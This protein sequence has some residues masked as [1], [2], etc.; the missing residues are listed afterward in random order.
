MEFPIIDCHAHI[1]PPLAGA[2]GLPMPPRICCTSSAPCTSTAT[3]RI[4]GR[5]TM[6]S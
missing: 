6:R 2:C 1:F 4:G 5:A 3:S